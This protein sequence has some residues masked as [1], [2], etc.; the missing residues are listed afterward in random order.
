MGRKERQASSYARR[1]AKRAHEAAKNRPFILHLPYELLAAIF[2]MVFHSYEG[3]HDRRTLGALSRT[4]VR[5][6]QVAKPMLFRQLDSTWGIEKMRIFGFPRPQ[7]ST[8]ELILSLVRHSLGDLVHVADFWAMSH[9]LG[10]FLSASYKAFRPDYEEGYHTEPDI[11]FCLLLEN[12]GVGMVSKYCPPSDLVAESSELPPCSSL[13]T[14]ASRVE[15]EEAALDPQGHWEHVRDPWLEG[16]LDKS[17]HPGGELELLENVAG[18]GGLDN[19]EITTENEDPEEDGDAI[20]YPQ[21]LYSAQKSFDFRHLTIAMALAALPNLVRVC[22]PIDRYS[23]RLLKIP[24][25]SN[26]YPVLIWCHHLECYVA[27]YSQHFPSLSELQELELVPSLNT[28]NNGYLFADHI[29]WIVQRSPD[30]RTLR[31]SGFEGLGGRIENFSLPCKNIT[32]LCLIGCN[33]PLDDL[34]LLLLCCPQLKGFKMARTNEIEC[35]LDPNLAARGAHL[36]LEALSNAAPQIQ[37]VS[38]GICIF[39]DDLGNSQRGRPDDK[40]LN[41]PTVGL[42]NLKTLGLRVENLYHHEAEEE[43]VNVLADLV[44][45]YPT[46]ESLQIFGGIYGHEFRLNPKL[47][48]WLDALERELAFNEESRLRIKLSYVDRDHYY[49]RVDD[50]YYSVVTGKSQFPDVNEKWSWH[51]AMGKRRRPIPHSQKPWLVLG[52]SGL[53]ELYRSRG[54]QIVLERDEGYE[55][56]IDRVRVNPECGREKDCLLPPIGDINSDESLWEISPPIW[57]RDESDGGD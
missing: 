30:L 54:V 18:E 19:D 4:C 8:C 49:R 44:K 41:L 26:A 51:E 36:V 22:L 46:L 10:D 14:D 47:K 43:N 12:M 38:L 42:T 11:P 31:L 29:S 17:L 45:N 32:T 39:L 3:E 21:I 25:K 48:S 33:I 55:I 9:D 13:S 15:P 20:C 34:R 53:V 40:G 16:E 5:F 52:K 57:T 35:R 6:R 1:V 2:E 56:P 27:L 28:H 37:K 24:T 7:I 50:Y 23:L